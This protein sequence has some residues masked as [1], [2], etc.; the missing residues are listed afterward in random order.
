[1]VDFSMIEYKAL[2]KDIMNVLL[3][4]KKLWNGRLGTNKA[5]H[6]TL[7][8][9]YETRSIRQEPYPAGKK[10]RETLCKHIDM[11]LKAGVINPVQ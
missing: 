5:T 4:H 2:K 3:K 8:L 11:R 9:K 1:M 7:N 6:H 10:Y